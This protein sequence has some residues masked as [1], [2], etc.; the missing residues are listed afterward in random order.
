M[1]HI[2]YAHL[3]TPHP[4][5]VLPFLH[6]IFPPKKYEIVV[7]SSKFITMYSIY[8]GIQFNE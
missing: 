8:S 4:I 2:D 6:D 7:F 1:P 5:D 3:G